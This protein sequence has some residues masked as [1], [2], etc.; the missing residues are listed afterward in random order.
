MFT[1]SRQLLRVSNR[2]LRQGSV[3]VHR[4]VVSSSPFYKVWWLLGDGCEWLSNVLFY[5]VRVTW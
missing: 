5:F 2:L 4:G 1:L 3:L